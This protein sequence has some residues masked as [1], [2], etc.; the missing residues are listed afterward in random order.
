MEFTFPTKSATTAIKSVGSTLQVTD[1]ENMLKIG[2]SFTPP[3]TSDL[4][5]SAISETIN[6]ITEIT[7]STE[8]S[9]TSEFLGNFTTTVNTLVTEVS[10]S[11]R[12]TSTIP[13]TFEN[14]TNSIITE[15]TNNATTITE[16]ERSSLTTTPFNVFSSSTDMSNATN[17]EDYE[18]EGKTLY[19]VLGVII[20][21][22]LL[23][24]IILIIIYKRYKA[25]RSGSLDCATDLSQ[26]TI[27]SG[28][29]K[30]Y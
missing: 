1:G 20:V 30:S 12:E 22:L 16:V 5:N 24:L 11:T 17:Y 13:D 15:I 28:R 25:R 6:T 2:Q 9:T 21:S 23:I 8:A 29:M 4:T 3:A 7:N 27:S 18:V 10:S 26:V 19:A 14:N